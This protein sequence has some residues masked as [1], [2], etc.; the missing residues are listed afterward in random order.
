MFYVK[1]YSG[2]CYFQI[3]KRLNLMNN[4]EIIQKS[5]NYKIKVS[6]INNLKNFYHNIKLFF[7]DTFLEPDF[8]C[9]P[10]SKGVY[11]VGFTI[12][13]LA[14]DFHRY[15]SILKMTSDIY[16]D[17]ITSMQL[18]KFSSEKIALEIEEE[19]F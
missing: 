17:I 4:D 11:I 16:K 14:F 5:Y 18:N 2:I 12:A 3:K 8:I 7:K 13:D 19:I 6:G 15:L 10:I 1:K 9:E